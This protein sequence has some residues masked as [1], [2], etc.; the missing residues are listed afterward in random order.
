MQGNES[1]VDVVRMIVAEVLLIE[2]DEVGGT[3]TMETLSDWDSLA[4]V[5]IVMQLESTLSIRLNY[6][7]IADIKGVE[8]L[9]RLAAKASL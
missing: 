9:A 6:K 1:V 3:S 8:D 5:Q 2:V 7:D 4:N